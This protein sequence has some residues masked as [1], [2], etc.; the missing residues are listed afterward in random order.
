MLFTHAGPLPK[1]RYV[2]IEPNAIGTHDWLPA[3]WFGLCAY[4]GRAWGCHVMLE[5]GAVYRN[6]PLHQLAHN[7]VAEPWTVKDAQMWDCYGWQFSLIEYTYFSGMRA[8]VKLTDKRELPGEYLFTAAPIGDGFSAT[9][10]QAKEFTFFALDNG[11]FTTQPTNR[12]L[13]EDRSFTS[14]DRQWPTFLKRQTE[15]FSCE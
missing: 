5:S 12:V 15:T 10:E 2:Y 3:V 4:P 7:K 6:I 11:R 8:T 13:F 1:H 14:K 9:P